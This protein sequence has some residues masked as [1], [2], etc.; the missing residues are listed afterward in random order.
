M[1][2]CQA[3]PLISG[4][5]RASEA[6]Q[7][8]LSRADGPNTKITMARSNS[9]D[10]DFA[11]P[12]QGG[13]G[14]LGRVREE[15]DACQTSQSSH[16]W[17]CLAGILLL[18]TALRAARPAAVLSLIFSTDPRDPRFVQRVTDSPFLRIEHF[19][20]SPKV[21]EKRSQRISTRRTGNLLDADYA[22]MKGPLKSRHTS[23]ERT[24]VCRRCHHTRSTLTDVSRSRVY[25]SAPRSAHS[26]SGSSSDGVNRISK[27]QRRLTRHHDAQPSPRTSPIPRCATRARWRDTAAARGRRAPGRC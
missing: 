9:L 12:G 1:D 5:G 25:P 3:G 23:S 7:P 15:Q 19:S 2:R 10:A 20:A 8:L 22:F 14:P 17:A 4:S 16:H 21:T 27:R 24:G 6:T 26:G 13:T 11:D 18:P